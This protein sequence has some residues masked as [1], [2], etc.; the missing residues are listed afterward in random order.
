MKYYSDEELIQLVNL[1]PGFGIDRLLKKIYPNIQKKLPERRFY[2]V[3]LLNHNKEEYGEDLYE[4]IQSTDYSK[5]V[6][7]NEYKEITGK[8]NL[9][10]GSRRSPNITLHP[11][12]FEWGE[13][14]PL[15]ERK[16]T[17]HDYEAEKDRL[18]LYSNIKLRDFRKMWDS[19]QLVLPVESPTL[20]SK[21]LDDDSPNAVI[22]WVPKM[23]EYHENNILEEWFEVT[24]TLR[25]IEENN[26]FDNKELKIVFRGTF[27][28][29]IKDPLNNERP[30]K[31][32]IFWV[33]NQLMEGY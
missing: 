23:I 16:V 8:K 30:T 33:F 19:Y 22:K 5:M 28:E 14:I 21:Y 17:K 9:P 20:V 10:K 31:E 15:E 26:T 13:V 6:N 32:D 1:N 18:R 11:Q 29:Y 27:E 2:L 12:D 25:V 4:I 7:Y 3:K 24:E